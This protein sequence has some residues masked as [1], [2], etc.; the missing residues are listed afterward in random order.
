MN[1]NLST[2]LSGVLAPGE[3]VGSEIYGSEMWGSF[4]F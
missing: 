1:D 4:G 2:R 3:E